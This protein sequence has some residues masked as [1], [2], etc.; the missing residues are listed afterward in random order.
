[1]VALLAVAGLLVVTLLVRP[2]IFSFADPRDDANYPL[3]AAAEADAGAREIEI[4]LSDAHGLAGE[5]VRDDRVGLTVVVAPGPVE[6]YTVV[7][8]WSPSNE[9][10]LTLTADRLVDCAQDAWTF[11]GIPLDAAVP[12]LQAFPVTERNGAVIVDFTRPMEA[13]RP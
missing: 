1:M 6:G 9:C 12:A 7:A 2:F 5:R 4:V 11:A 10:A 8:A 3:I 13:G